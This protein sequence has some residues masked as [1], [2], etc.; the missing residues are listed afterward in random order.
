MRD[1]WKDSEYAAATDGERTPR[2]HA[3]NRARAS[4]GRRALNLDEYN[5]RCEWMA[6]YRDT[7]DPD[8]RAHYVRLLMDQD[9]PVLRAGEFPED[10]VPMPDHI[11]AQV[12]AVIGKWSIEPMKAGA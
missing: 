2:L 5:A 10:L 3:Y 12:E 11:R 1:P 4:R 9:K 7:S 6:I 8:E